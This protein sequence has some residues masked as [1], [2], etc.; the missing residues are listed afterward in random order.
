MLF[1]KQYEI[2]ENVPKP[3]EWDE[4]CEL[5]LEE[6]EI[7]LANNSDKEDVFQKFF[8]ENPSFLPGAMELFG[9]SGHY[10]YMDALISQP[11]IGG[12]F[13]RRPDFVWLAN[14]SLT[15]VP[16]FIEIEKPNK[17]MFNKDG[18][19][20]AEFN[21]ALGQIHEWQYIL[22]Q[23][24]NI[25]ILY[26]YFNLPLDF[27]EMTFKPQYLLI[28][29]R[30]AEY[31]GNKRLTGIRAA[32]KTTNIDIMSYD[33]LKPISDYKQFVTCKVSGGLYTVKNISPTFRYRPDCAEELVKMQGF[34]SKIDMM[35]QTSDDRKIF[36]KDR[37]KYW[38]EFGQREF[39]GIIRSQEGE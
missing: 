36:L 14:D 31:K 17:K 27:R 16:V 29:G 37:Y 13:R 26:D 6:Y 25:Q 7:L 15:F 22:N 21:Q 12:L 2:M 3:I 9:H 1:E 30:R 39:K 24:I 33:R 19:T 11:E 5:S 4:Y 8:E 32:N 34:S 38:Y 35:K 10:P 18:T 28:Y 20:T 23:S